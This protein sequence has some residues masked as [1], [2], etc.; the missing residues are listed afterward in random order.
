MVT[1]C[2][3]HINGLVQGVGFRPFVYQIAQKYSISGHVYNSGNGVYIHCEATHENRKNFIDSLQSE[4]PKVSRIDTFTLTE[5]AVENLIGFEIIKSQTETK[6]T[7]IVPDMAMC[8]ACRFELQDHQN[9]RYNY[10]FI[11]CTDCGPRYSIIDAIPYDRENTSMRK[12]KMCDACESEYRDPNN[13][14]FHAEPISCYE[15]GPTLRLLDSRGEVIKSKTPIID[16]AKAL[17]NG[18][19]VAVKGLGGF[20]LLCDATNEK[21]VKLLR[22]H[23]GRIFKPFAVMCKD[24]R[25]VASHAHVST[26]EMSYLTGV[27]KPI[28]LVSKNRRSTLASMVAPH[29]DQLGLF[30]PYTPLHSLLLDQLDFPL[31]VSS[32]NRSGEGILCESSDVITQ[33]GDG[34]DLI[35]DHNRVIVNPIDDSVVQV[36][37]N[38][39]MVLRHGRGFAPYTMP[40]DTKMDMTVL[41]VGAQ[42]KSTIAMAFEKMLLLSPYIAE[43]GSVNSVESFETMVDRLRHFY[44]LE[45]DVIGHD[46]HPYYQSTQWA[47]KQKTKTIPLQ[48]HYAHILAVMAEYGLKERVLGFSYDGTGLGDDGTTIWGGESFIANTQNYEHIASLRPFRLL[49]GDKAS[50]EPRRVALALLFEIFTLDE[51]LNL[52]NPTVKAFSTQE[53]RLLHQVWKKGLNTPK[54]SSMGR[55]FDGMASLCGVVQKLTYE[56]ESGLRLDTFYDAILPQTIYT[57]TYEHNTLDWGMM[58]RQ[59]LILEDQTVAITRFYHTIVAMM[60]T[61]AK[62]TPDLP[63]VLSGGV[64]QNRYLSELV[65][66]HFKQK[67]RRCYIGS[68]IPANDSAIALGQAWHIICNAAEVK[69]WR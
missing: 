18:K 51:V 8:D 56:G 65:L 34:I 63:V 11:N 26:L 42:Q 29:I 60:A 33:L 53:I 45:V 6:H 52:S 22:Q 23:K 10:P 39:L 9:R 5:R 25:A 67:K 46:I 21:S 43:L 3:L 28:V 69:S 2:S 49:G 16:T 61:I 36:V 37:D 20:H 58:V 47:K 44:A 68:Q 15:C 1:A 14:R 57:F 27:S 32:A 17:Q 40:L 41:A 13:R 38:R 7:A 19:I 12:F 30:L 48:H 66:D 55:L 62:S 59:M 64:F 35:L 31:V 4:L 54:C 50:Q 24:T